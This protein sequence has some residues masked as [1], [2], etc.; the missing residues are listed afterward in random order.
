MYKANSYVQKVFE[1]NLVS[2]EWGNRH[3]QN[4]QAFPICTC[5]LYNVDIQNPAKQ[6]YL[7]YECY[8]NKSENQY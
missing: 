5:K 4:Q 6:Q 8:T 1:R 2:L 7:V 3:I